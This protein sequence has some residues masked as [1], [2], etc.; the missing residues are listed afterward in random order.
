MHADLAVSPRVTPEEFNEQENAPGLVRRQL[1]ASRAN[2]P[3]SMRKYRAVCVL[4]GRLRARILQFLSLLF[5]LLFS[6][7]NGWE[8]D[9]IPC[10]IALGI[11]R[12]NIQRR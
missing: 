1:C 5:L 7:P 2:E 11:R 10:L 12:G 4:D 9:F 6:I 3:Q 8:R